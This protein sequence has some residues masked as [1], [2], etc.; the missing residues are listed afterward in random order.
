MS[1]KDA[2]INDDSSAKPGG[3]VEIN[4]KKYFYRAYKN[5]RR[6][7]LIGFDKYDNQPTF[8]GGVVFLSGLFTVMAQSAKKSDIDKKSKA[9]KLLLMLAVGVYAAIQLTVAILGM[10][11]LGIMLLLVDD[12]LAKLYALSLLLIALLLIVG[13]LRM[14]PPIRFLWKSFRGRY[15][16]QV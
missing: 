4:K 8:M 15:A 13:S 7:Y 6:F 1:N 14:L 9:V 12:V 11:R 2:F 10:G 5:D 3:I 16:E